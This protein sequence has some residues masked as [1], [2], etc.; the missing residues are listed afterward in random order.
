M[1]KFCII[2]N[3]ITGSRAKICSYGTG[4]IKSSSVSLPVVLDGICSGMEPEEIN[5]G[6]GCTLGTRLSLNENLNFLLERV[7]VSQGYHSL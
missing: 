6:Q 5:I 2:S 1:T 4:H 7:K 3:H